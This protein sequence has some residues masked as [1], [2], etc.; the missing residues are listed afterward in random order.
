LQNAYAKLV[1]DCR[2]LEAAFAEVTKLNGDLAFELRLPANANAASSHAA[3]ARVV[4]T[5]PIFA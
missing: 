2:R 5:A 3:I 1:E 4:Q